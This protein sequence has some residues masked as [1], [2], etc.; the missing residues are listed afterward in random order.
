MS[1][2]CAWLLAKQ[3]PTEIAAEGDVAPLEPSQE[4]KPLLPLENFHFFF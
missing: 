2:G 4:A 1:T 3:V